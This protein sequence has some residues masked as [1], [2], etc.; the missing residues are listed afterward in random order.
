MKYGKNSRIF[1]IKK[2]ITLLTKY[3][4]NHKH[5][6]HRCIKKGELKETQIYPKTVENTKK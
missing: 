2:E 1:W 5:P 4:T 6:F 3:S